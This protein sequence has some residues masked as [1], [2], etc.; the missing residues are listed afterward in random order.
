MMRLMAERKPLRTLPLRVGT[1]PTSRVAVIQPGSWRADKSST[2]RGYSYKWQQA[3]ALFLAENPLCVMCKQETP[4]RLT[5]ATVVDHRIPHRGDSGIFWDQ[6]N[7]QSL[8]A[9]HHSS[10]KQSE[11]H[12]Q[13]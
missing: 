4:P 12:R 1:S 8:C 5:V 2:Q 7:W 13:K 6:E 10:H 11:E 3:R 9:N